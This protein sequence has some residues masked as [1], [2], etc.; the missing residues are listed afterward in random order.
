MMLGVVT[1]RALALMRESTKVDEAKEK[2][3]LKDGQDEERNALRSLIESVDLQRAR[4]GELAV[5]DG[6][7]RLGGV[8]SS[9]FGGAAAGGVPKLLTVEASGGLLVGGLV[10]GR[11]CERWGEEWM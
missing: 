4:V 10:S 6:E 9:G 3:P 7:A 1:P 8:D 5:V 11:H 2:R